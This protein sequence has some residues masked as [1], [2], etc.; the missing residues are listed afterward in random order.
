MKKTYL[1]SGFFT[2]AAFF[3][4]NPN[5]NII[6]VLPDCIGYLLIIFGI[7]RLGDLV[8]HFAEAQAAF[9]R[10]FW[11]SLIKMPAFMITMNLLAGN[12]SERP[13]YT[14]VALAFGVIELIFLFPA[15]RELFA[16]MDYL[17][18]RYGARAPIGPRAAKACRACYI[19]LGAKP[20]LAFLPEMS[21]ISMS[22]Y[23]TSASTD[24]ARFRP[25]LTVLFCLI[26]LGFGIYFLI[27]FLPFC[28]EL[29]Q[30]TETKDI[31]ASLAAGQ[32]APLRGS[33]CIHR[34]GLA[35]SLAVGGVSCMLNLHF[36][37]IN[38]L[39]N[40]LGFLCFTVM[41][42]V[43]LPLAKR[44]IPVL[45]CALA[46][47]GASLVA[48]LQRAT[49]FQEFG[50]HRLG[51]SPEADALYT[52][53]SAFSVAEG[54]LLIAVC[55][56]SCLLFDRVVRDHTGYHADNVNNY[57]SHL[58]LHAALR[59]MSIFWTCIGSL[60]AITGAANILLRRLTVKVEL[61]PDY[62]YSSAIMPIFGGFWLVPWVLTLG[63]IAYTLYL[64]SSIN[65]ET[66]QKYRLEG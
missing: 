46:G 5:I 48:Y 36:D 1:R 39:P 19:A 26:G 18:E 7:R 12:G 28:R 49:F 66:L 65:T 33:D 53:Y 47:A 44:A 41:A 63:W 58:S 10:L 13:L 37:G 32:A 14:V 60:V 22:D 3:L 29:R 21:L 45:V 23:I 2:A 55:V 43:L 24:P 50:Y 31:L 35:M 30:D 15:I 25:H 27:A 8:P 4:F 6:D 20:I 54:I 52:S 17:G 11:L 42:I 57:S 61:S 40:T 62:A 9:R 34:I 38:Y 16:G 59:R 64:T 56:L 51:L